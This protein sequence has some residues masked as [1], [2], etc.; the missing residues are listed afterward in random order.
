MTF[1]INP[2]RYATAGGGGGAFP[3]FTNLWAH[4]D[5]DQETVVAD[6][7]PM[8]QWTDWSGNGRH[9]TQSGANRPLY[10]ASKFNSK[11]AIKCETSVAKWFTVP[12]MSALTEAHYFVVIWMLQDTSDVPGPGTGPWDMSADRSLGVIFA[13]VDNQIYDSWGST[14][15]KNFGKGGFSGIPLNQ[16]NLYEVQTAPGLW[17]AYLNGTLLHS[18]ASNTVGFNSSPLFGQ[19]L[20]TLAWTATFWAAEVVICS[21]VQSEGIRANMRDYVNSEYALSVI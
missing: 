17:K 3:S 8:S 11:P 4:Y 15:R 16:A 1:I 14:A 12:D 19:T 9:M 13:Y 21:S 18:T 5:T 6:G 7:T 2:Y 20:A 10:I